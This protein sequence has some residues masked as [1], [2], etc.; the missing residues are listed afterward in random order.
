MNIE[1]LKN[2]NIYESLTYSQA[3]P[4]AENKWVEYYPFLEKQDWSVV[5]SLP[6][7]VTKDL[8]LQSLQY[9]IIHRYVGC[10]YNLYNWKIVDSP[11]C[12]YCS[13]LDTIEHLYYYC[14]EA[15][16]IWNALEKLSKD[17][18]LLN[19]NLTVLEVLLG[20]PHIANTHSQILNLLILVGKQCI[21]LSR[22]KEHHVS[23]HFFHKMAQYVLETE[24]YIRHL[25]QKQSDEF[26]DL[27]KQILTSLS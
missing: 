14:N 7:K 17:V 8:K 22:C 26:L 25:H 19:S 6:S 24:M 1:K 9:S 5:Y 21:Y 4:T 23:L 3:I 11:L 20:I 10:N 2:K 15:K 27:C 13:E 12:P 18:L 16:I